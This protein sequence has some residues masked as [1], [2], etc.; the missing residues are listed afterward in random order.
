MDS[1]CDTGWQLRART[2]NINDTRPHSQPGLSNLSS[3]FCETRDWH[4]AVSV[5]DTGPGI[6]ENTRK[7]HD[8]DGGHDDSAHLVSNDDDKKI[9]SGRG[10]TVTIREPP[11]HTLT[12]RY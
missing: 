12:M 2:Q 9:W 3:A 1:L 5:T 11:R 7:G 10:G 6:A 4:G 8:D